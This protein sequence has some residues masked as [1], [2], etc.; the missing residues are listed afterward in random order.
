MACC[1][2]MY[3][4]AVVLYFSDLLKA[5]SDTGMMQLLEDMSRRL[6]MFVPTN[7]AFVVM[8]SGELGRRL[9]QT[10]YTRN[11]R[12]VST[13]CKVSKYCKV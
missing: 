3:C 8:R 1:A 6:T 12:N 9:L 7:E 11:L 4:V 5:L 10:E 13:Q 2:G